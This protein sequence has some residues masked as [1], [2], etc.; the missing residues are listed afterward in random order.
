MTKLSHPAKKGIYLLPNLFTTGALFAGYY[1]IIAS[2]NGKFEVAAIAIFIAALLDGLDGRVARLTNTQSAFGE[3]YDSLSD[4]ISFGL[5]PSLLMYNWSLS[6]LANIHPIMGKI[7][8]L[9]AFIYTVSGALRLARFNVQIGNIDKAYFQGLPSPAAAAVISSFVWVAVDHQLSGESLKYVTL[10]VTLFAGLLMVSRFRYYSFKTLPFKESVP[11]VWVLL[12]VLI[13]VML[14]LAPAKV[15]FVVFS[16]YSF[17]GVL[18]TLY[19]I[20]QKRDKKEE[21]V[22]K[23]LATSNDQEHDNE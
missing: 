16:L 6:H 2:I 10:G 15:L 8:W 20:K 4:L 9:V 1:S 19:H 12:L 3:Q 23:P 22:N 7:G 14:A 21:D 5:A 13:F 11:F 18:M 17:S